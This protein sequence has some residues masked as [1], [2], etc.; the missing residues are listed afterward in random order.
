MLSPTEQQAGHAAELDQKWDI[1]PSL[2]FPKSVFHI[3]T[4]IWLYVFGTLMTARA[5][6]NFSTSVVI[7]SLIYGGGAQILVELNFRPYQLSLALIVPNT[8]YTKITHTYHFYGISGNTTFTKKQFLLSGCKQCR[9][10]NHSLPH[11]VQA[12][13]ISKIVHKQCCPCT[14]V[15]GI[16]DF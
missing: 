10:A 3:K 4:H 15:S 5:H 8:T 11:K 7:V 2:E 12:V 16:S 14:L 9:L 6:H 1:L 13:Q